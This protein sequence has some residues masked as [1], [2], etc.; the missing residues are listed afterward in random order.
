MVLERFCPGVEPGGRPG[1]IAPDAADWLRQHSAL[2]ALGLGLDQVQDERA[3]DA[4][5]VKMA[6]ID[7][8][9]VEQRD[10]V[11]GIGP[12]RPAS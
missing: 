7:P 2:H 6:A 5:A 9:V 8:Q 1:A 10:V 12:S 3:A 11:G 4:L